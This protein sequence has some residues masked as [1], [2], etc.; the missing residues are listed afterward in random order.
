[1]AE[2]PVASSTTRRHSVTT[3][4]RLIFIGLVVLLMASVVY[5]LGTSW[6]E[7]QALAQISQ[8]TSAE[9]ADI[10]T[11]PLRLDA[12]SLDYLAEMGNYSHQRPEGV[13]GRSLDVYYSRRAY[14]GAPPIIPHPVQDEA[15]FGG[16]SCLSCHATGSY[17]PAMAIFAPIVPHPNLVAC[18][19]CHVPVLDEGELFQASDWQRSAPVS[20]I[21]AALV[22]A[23]PPMPHPLQ[24]RENCAA[25]HTGAA[26][27]AEIVVD[28]IERESCQQCHVASQTDD[29]WVRTSQ[30]IP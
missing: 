19:Q 21:E 5:V 10:P 16:K 29:A 30:E 17:A 28:H 18:T 22:G 14:N 15:S 20:M 23:P 24:M 9:Q 7:G 11:E 26:A 2:Q 27:P 1:M 8:Q 12:G 6:N 4:F 3:R 25:C 13:E